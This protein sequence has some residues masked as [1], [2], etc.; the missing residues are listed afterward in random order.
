MHIVLRFVDR[1]KDNMYSFVCS[2][3]VCGTNESVPIRTVYM[4]N[5]QGWIRCRT[6]FGTHNP[7]E[8]FWTIVTVN[9]ADCSWTWIVTRLDFTK[10][11]GQPARIVQ[12]T[13]DAVSVQYI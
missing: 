11:T 13:H 5:R 4:V 10:L 1:K 6:C 3:L 7:S 2:L 12:T 9:S 8:V